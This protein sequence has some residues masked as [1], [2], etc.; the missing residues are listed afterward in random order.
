VLAGGVAH[1]LNNTLG[2]IIGYPEILL[3]DLPLESPFRDPLEK[4]QKTGMKAARIANDMLALTRRGIVTTEVF[5]LNAIITDYFKSLEFD[6]LITYHR[7]VRL[8]IR[9]DEKPLTSGA[10][11][12][13]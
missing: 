2:S 9:T 11:F 13:T 7:E 5:N 4:I 3:M 1:D 10:H 6:R 12:S 8:D